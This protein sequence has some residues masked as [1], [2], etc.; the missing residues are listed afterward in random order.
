MTQLE[1]EKKSEI[2][3]SHGN[4]VVISVEYLYLRVEQ[5]GEGDTREGGGVY[6]IV[7]RRMYTRTGLNKF[8]IGL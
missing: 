7:C 1:L 3:L 4:Y 6:E 2:Y 8:Q 5:L